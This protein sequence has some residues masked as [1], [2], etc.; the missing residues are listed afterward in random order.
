[1]KLRLKI[2]VSNLIA[3]ILFLV[4]LLSI[5]MFFIPI[6]SAQGK[7]LDVGRKVI[8][9]ETLRSKERLSAEI[10]HVNNTAYLELANIGNVKS[11]A[12]VLYLRSINNTIKIKELKLQLEP[13]ERTIIETPELTYVSNYSKVSILTNYGNV[14][15]VIDPQQT[16]GTS[17]LTEFNN[18][19]PDNSLVPPY[20]I[21]SL[22]NDVDT[23][24]INLWEG[25]IANTKLWYRNSV[26]EML[27]FVS[28]DNL[29]YYV[30]WYF[31]AN[32][33][34]WDNLT[35]SENSFSIKERIY[36]GANLGKN[37]K[38][39]YVYLI[40]LPNSEN[41]EDITANITVAYYVK[42]KT[43]ADYVIHEIYLGLITENSLECI[44]ITNTSPLNDYNLPV[45][46]KEL[47]TIYVT[48]VLRI[49]IGGWRSDTRTGIE[50]YF[51]K[52]EFPLKTTTKY[53]AIIIY[54]EFH[55]NS[56]TS[57]NRRVLF[58]VAV[59]VNEITVGY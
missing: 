4:L 9:L 8:E 41:V 31:P 21:S 47:Q 25:D 27:V 50:N 12:D 49:K 15:Y 2:G 1:M 35:M 7:F 59:Q 14:F 45:Q 40:E 11:F 20:T 29:E 36:E 24:P 33:S 46:N 16:G 48:K 3:S 32:T 5:L 18:T 10:Y 26:N 38:H 13:G 6:A 42:A 19:S 34:Y 54:N 30:T 28:K 17:L 52:M 53:L 37:Q 51:V 58:A 56:I 23:L 55:T 43:A 39:W 22:V 57:V 44:S